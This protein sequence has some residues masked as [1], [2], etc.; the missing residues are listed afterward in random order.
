MKKSNT[1]LVATGATA[2]STVC[3]AANAG[4]ASYQNGKLIGIIVGFI[5]W[6]LICKKL[7]SNGTTWGK[8]LGVAILV[9]GVWRGYALIASHG[10]ADSAG[11]LSSIGARLSGDIP[12]SE[13]RSLAASVN[14]GEVTLYTTTDCPYCAEAKRWLNQYGF[15]YSECDAQVRERCA[16]DLQALGALG[17]PFLRV[18]GKSMKDG[19]DSDEFVALLRAASP[20]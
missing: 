8:V 4:S 15:A 18:R 1:W 20:Q 11:A 10:M 3:H 13:L 2:L 16:D 19:F 12:D 7:L 9:I 6:A 5:L 17:V 14:P